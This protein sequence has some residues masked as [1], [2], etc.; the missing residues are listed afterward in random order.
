VALLFDGLSF[1]TKKARSE[2]DFL[3]DTF[4]SSKEKAKE[5][6]LEIKRLKEEQGFTEKDAQVQVLRAKELDF[7]KDA[8]IAL[9]DFKKA[10][11]AVNEE[12]KKASD[13][14]ARTKQQ[15][16]IDAVSEKSLKI[17]EIE[18]GL[19]DEL[20]RL[21]LSTLD[22]KLLQF[23]KERDKKI[24]AGASAE[25]ADIVF[26]E[27]SIKL[28]QD[29]QIKKDK[30][31]NKQIDKELKEETKKRDEIKKISKDLRLDIEK[32]A[33]SETGKKL[34]QLREQI[35]NAEEAGVDE[36]L[37]GEFTASELEKIRDDSSDE[38]KDRE[39]ELADFKRD[40]SRRVASTV[41]DI[42]EGSQESFDEIFKQTA[43]SFAASM[44]EMAVQ[45]AF[46]SDVIEIEMA[47]ATAG[48]SLLLGLLGQAFLAPGGRGG[49][50]AIKA[51]SERVGEVFDKFI[52]EFGNTL[53]DFRLSITQ[54]TERISLLSDRIGDSAI[55]IE[56]SFN[57]LGQLQ[58]AR[59][60]RRDEL[61]LDTTLFTVRDIALERIESE[62]VDV[63]NTIGDK[64]LEVT[65]LIQRRYNEELSLIEE[66]GDKI[67][68]LRQQQK[69]FVSDIDETIKD[70][71]RRAL[72]PQELLDVS[73]GDVEEIQSR[74]LNATGQEKIDLLRE[75]E[76][77]QLSIFDLVE[78]IF[79]TDSREFR[80]E[81]ENTIKILED[82][83]ET[84]TSEFQ[85]L[86]DVETQSLEKLTGIKVDLE[87]IDTSIKSMIDALNL[88]QD[89]AL[90]TL[91][92]IGSGGAAGIDQEAIAQLISFI[93][94]SSVTQFANGG[95]LGGQF[96]PFG[97]AANSSTFSSPTLGLIGEGRLREAVVPL[98]DG[99]SIPARIVDNGPPTVIHVNVENMFADDVN[100]VI[101]KIVE[102][103]RKR[104][105]GDFN[106]FVR[107][108]DSQLLNLQSA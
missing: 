87:N 31:L 50:Q 36:V 7:L 22:F 27:K 12:R 21:S 59:Q 57:R 97:G 105:I 101:D 84:G 80:E 71:S 24:E 23:E 41:I 15:T 94:G 68:D 100:Q 29:E 16:E 75:L 83:K 54:G 40:V 45:A 102:D 2:M 30:I 74:L 6:G 53:E 72:S 67:R 106:N 78:K 34:I 17:K 20:E 76:V 44:I 47:A 1:N 64:T 91:E 55:I 70:V 89:Q 99:E 26:A 51:F 5:L 98:P 3:S 108:Q 18:Q 61:G 58:T 48:V 8:Q 82:I 38:E 60:Q 96:K 77:A 103:N 86:I 107:R 19:R 9:R 37:I 62:I 73:R 93:T 85:L 25:L 46:T 11:Q 79:G 14:A 95:T 4:L 32:N 10:Q 88:R 35:R 42:F 33:A 52:D 92:L 69:S 66:T 43:K 90:R 104:N 63:L 56:S 28:L 13:T 39:R 81:Q 49:G 65:D